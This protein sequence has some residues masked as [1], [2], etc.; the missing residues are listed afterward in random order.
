MVEMNMRFCHDVSQLRTS[1]AKSDFFQTNNFLLRF[2]EKKLAS[3][4]SGTIYADVLFFTGLSPELGALL[5]SEAMVDKPV[6][7]S[8]L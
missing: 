2:L 7:P 3:V 6:H 5:A 4:G 8:S 1:C